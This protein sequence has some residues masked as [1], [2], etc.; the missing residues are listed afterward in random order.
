MTIEEAGL[1][2][3]VLHFLADHLSRK[4]S[5]VKARYE[6]L[7]KEKATSKNES[8]EVTLN[9]YLDND[10]EAALAS[11]D[12]LYC[13]RCFVFDCQL[14][15][16][17]Q[18]LIFPAE[19]QA[20]WFSADENKQPCGLNCYLTVI[21][22]QSDPNLASQQIVIHE[23]NSISSPEESSDGVWRNENIEKDLGKDKRQNKRT[24]S[25]SYSFGS[26]SSKS[27]CLPSHKNN[28]DDISSSRKE[29]SVPETNN[30]LLDIV[31]GLNM[32]E[33]IN[34]KHMTSDFET[35]KE[36][37][38]LGEHIFPIEGNSN[39][40]WRPLEKTLFE[41]G[42]EIFGRSSCLIARN[43]MNG[44]RS[45]IE[46]FQYM[47]LPENKTHAQ[48]GVG[49]EVMGNGGHRRSRYA[50]RSGRVRH[51][52]YT[53]KS[54]GH[55]SI[56]KRIAVKKEELEKHYTLCNC[57]SH[58][59]KNCPCTMKS[60]SCE[61]FCGC[62]KNCP[63]RFRG[64]HCS[65]SQCTTDDCPCYAAR[66]EC[67]P[68][69]CHNC[70]VGCGD[71]SIGFHPQRVSNH[72]CMNMKLLLRQHQKVLLGRSDIAGWGAF[73]KN[74]VKK[75]DFIGEY[76]GEVISHFEADKR[77]K[78]YD[79]ENYSFLFNLNDMLVVDAYRKG[80]KLKFANHSLQPNCVAKVVMV[81]GDHRIGIYAST[82][83][84]PGDELLY[85]YRYEPDS[86]PAWAKGLMGPTSSKK[87]VSRP[88][89]R[90][91]VGLSLRRVLGR[92][93]RSDSVSHRI[94]SRQNPLAF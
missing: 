75:N 28:H 2:D 78:V 73:L 16:C 29:H 34:Y 27:L 45:C 32:I 24:A 21:N 3:T 31:T 62:S 81:G 22:E 92:A 65:K 53:C 17:S 86:C 9:S 77:G 74:S 23:E 61:K 7:L 30:S 40:D 85:D 63:I 18:D 10:L 66:R 26:S 43:L 83:I 36:D 59:G 60:G 11:F 55:H 90:H 52:R 67:D 70:L 80:N 46:V 57:K 12:N 6:Y 48:A 4:P 20:P 5:E 93:L 51:F 15:G 88:S 42:L 76:T 84:D 69:I 64:C 41:K 8:S 56:R 25:R 82:P 71:G 13:R 1:S 79:R 68:D 37:A 33:A 54:G 44:L 87:E 14:H 47:N 94:A 58:C 38:F 19:K 91:R 50:R 49:V 89:G 72:Q 39:K 35:A